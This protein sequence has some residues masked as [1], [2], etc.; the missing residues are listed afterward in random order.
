M[1]ELNEIV[2]HIHNT[3]TNPREK[4]K[5]VSFSSTIMK[6][7]LMKLRA[8]PKKMRLLVSAGGSTCEVIDSLGFIHIKLRF[9]FSGH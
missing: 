2:E 8:V 6:N 3:F 7:I 5:M 9:L 4:R 1:L